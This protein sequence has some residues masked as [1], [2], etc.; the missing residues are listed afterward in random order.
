MGP[1][2]MAELVELK[3]SLPPDLLAYV[4]QQAART[5]RTPSGV[6]RHWIAEQKRR[7]PPDHAPAFPAEIAP[8][9][10][11]VAANPKAIAEAKERVTAL[12][13]ERAAIH[14]RQRLK[15]D[16]AADGRRV[17]EINSEIEVTSNRIAMAERMANGGLNA[18]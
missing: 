2:K 16:T 17:D 11:G 12:R 8:I 6:I 14:H 13:Q 1:P 4:Q 7:E 9:I 18:V 3:L 15:N 10:P 5:D